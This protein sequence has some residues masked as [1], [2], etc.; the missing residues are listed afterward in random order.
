MPDNHKAVV[1]FRSLDGKYYRSKGSEIGQATYEFINRLLDKAD[2]EEQAYKS[3]MG[4]ISFSRTYGDYR[5]ENGM[6]ESNFT[7]LCIILNTEEHPEKW[8]GVSAS[9]Y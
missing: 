1:A 5:V 7:Q 4:V 3:C 8:S 9:N 2:F 6:Q